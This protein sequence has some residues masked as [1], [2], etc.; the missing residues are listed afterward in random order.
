MQDHVQ[1]YMPDQ[2]QTHGQAYEQVHKSSH[3]QVR[4]R[5]GAEHSS[6]VGGPR[7]HSVRGND[8][9]DHVVGGDTVRDRPGGASIVMGGIMRDF[10]L[11]DCSVTVSYTH[12]TL[13][14]T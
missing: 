12:L 9:M 4:V 14:T 11:G 5:S 1:R 6:R 2:G 13:P 8:G 10:G 3:V 7:V